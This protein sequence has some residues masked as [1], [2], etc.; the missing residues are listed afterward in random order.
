MKIERIIRTFTGT[1]GGVFG[2]IFGKTDG[3]IIAL[4][5]FVIA[6]YLTG[7][8]AAVVNKEI[9]SDIGYKGLLKKIGIFIAVAIANAIDVYVLKSGTVMR[10][11]TCL[12]YI[13]ND[14]ISIVENLFHIGVPFPA[15]LKKYFAQIKTDDKGDEENESD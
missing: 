9:S 8:I 3:F 7:V 11:A 4:L 14:G 10:S 13:A 5:S 12:F 1:L 15:K 6:D 2:Y